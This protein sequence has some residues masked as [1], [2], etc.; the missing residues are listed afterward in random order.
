MLI[1]LPILLILGRTVQ[2]GKTRHHKQVNLAVKVKE[3]FII[4]YRLVKN[5]RFAIEKY[6]TTEHFDFHVRLSI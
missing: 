1:M 4:Q 2:T 3:Y 6:D 5:I